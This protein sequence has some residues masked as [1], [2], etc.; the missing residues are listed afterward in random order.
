ATPVTEADLGEPLWGTSVR[1]EDLFESF[2]DWPRH[3]TIGAT[4]AGRRD[5]WIVESY[6]H[7]DKPFPAVRS[8]VGVE[9]DIPLVIERFDA[10]GELIARIR[11]DKLIFR[12]DRGWLPVVLTVETPATQERATIRFTRSD[13]D[14]VYT[15]EEFTPEGVRA[16]SA[17]AS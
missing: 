7:E 15:P 14:V 8:C 12:E 9:E 17:P 2:W 11:A 3:A 10:E 1:P 5:C 13:R 16:L 4:S 6:Q